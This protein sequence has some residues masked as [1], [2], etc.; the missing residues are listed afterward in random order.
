VPGISFPLA[1]CAEYP[2]GNFE[3]DSG[4]RGRERGRER[5]R[6]REREIWTTRRILR[7]LAKK[8]VGRKRGREDVEAPARMEQA[9]RWRLAPGGFFVRQ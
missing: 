1:L 2:R 3:E 7:E 6:K 9:E 5:E 4:A 8:S